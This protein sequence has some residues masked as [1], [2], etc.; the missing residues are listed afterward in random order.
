[1]RF[2]RRYHFRSGSYEVWRSGRPMGS[3]LHAEPELLHYSRGHWN[4]S[5]QQQPFFSDKGIQQVTKVLLGAGSFL[6][7]GTIRNVFALSLRTA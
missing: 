6:F 5:T 1:M 4:V 2:L 7:R 3:F